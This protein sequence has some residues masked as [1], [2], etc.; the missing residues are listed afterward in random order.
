MTAALC[1][2]NNNS[3]SSLR[4]NSVVY[5]EMGLSLKGMIPISKSDLRI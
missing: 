2:L 3:Q 1:I 5:L 4:Y